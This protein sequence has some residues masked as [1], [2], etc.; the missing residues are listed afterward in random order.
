MD[1][2]M[3]GNY[4]TTMET[5]AMT[6]MRKYASVKGREMSCETRVDQKEKKMTTMIVHRGGR[7]E[8][9]EERH[10]YRECSLGKQGHIQWKGRC[11]GRERVVI[12]GR[13][14]PASR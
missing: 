4:M 5:P 1:G 13:C 7:G 11:V 6:K 14:G 2:W 9:P 12:V 10:R 3:D 8:R